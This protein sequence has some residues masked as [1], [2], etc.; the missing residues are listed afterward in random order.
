MFYTSLSEL[1]KLERQN[2]AHRRAAFNSLLSFFRGKS[3]KK[4]AEQQRHGARSQCAGAVDD[5][6]ESLF[7]GSLESQVSSETPIS[8]SGVREMLLLDQSFAFHGEHVAWGRIGE[9]PP[10]I[11][12]HGFPWSAQAWRR[13][14]PWIAD[15]YTVYYYDMIGCGQSSKSE[16]QSVHPE[17]QNKLLAALID[18]WSIDRPHVVGHDFGGLAALRGHLI[19]GLE[20][21]SL[22]L[23]DS[24]ALLPS[25]SPFFAHAQAHNESMSLLPDFVHEAVFHAFI[26]FGSFDELPKNV[27]DMYFE[28]WSGRDG[29]AAF[30]RQ[31]AQSTNEP[32]EEIQSRLAPLPFPVDVIWGKHDRNIPAELGR[33]LADKLAARSF[34]AVPGAAH[35]VQE[36]APEA[37]IGLLRSRL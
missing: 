7:C 32:L 11:L 17:V 24:V 16:T 35:I 26:N 8:R 31:I 18:H 25:G 15:Q 10:I 6:L 22:T 12:I 2:L 27:R 1:K 29:Q 13:I 21:E 28:P 34:T 5:G 36:D 3:A 14:A 20:Y 23:I 30:Y 9:G 4:R 19:E 37:I 33:Q